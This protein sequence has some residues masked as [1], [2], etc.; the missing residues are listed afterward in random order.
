MPSRFRDDLSDHP[1]LARRREFFTRHILIQTHIPKTAGTSLSNGIQGI[2]GAV[3]SAD[4]R[5]RRATP[6]E[7]L[8]DHDL[9]RLHFVSG[10]FSYG[11]HRPFSRRE[12]Y[13]AAVRDPVD[14][15]ISAY[16]FL[17]GSPKHP[18]F[19]EVQNLDFGQAYDLLREREGILGTN[20]QSK[21]LAGHTHDWQK[22]L[23]DPA[24]LWEHLDR[25]YLIVIPHAQ[26]TKAINAFREAFGVPWSKP[27]SMNVSKGFE[28]APSQELRSR[29]LSD[30]TVDAELFTRITETFE[31]RLQQACAYIA[32]RCLKPLSPTGATDRERR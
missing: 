12:L 30:N 3:N 1:D 26:V 16:R 28:T 6:L 19:A 5:W 21:M 20:R 15:A 9:E 10:H 17:R 22:S 2:V 29:I 32:E 13:L 25:A 11:D 24:D 31:H 27:V 14:R 4:L 7:E 23:P 18:M 8:S